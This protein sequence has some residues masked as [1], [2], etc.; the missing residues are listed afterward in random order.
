LKSMQKNCL[1][2]VFTACERAWIS[3]DNELFMWSYE[4]GEDLAYYDGINDTIIA[5]ELA[6][7]RPGLFTNFISH[8]DNRRSAKWNILS[9]V[10]CH[11]FGSY[12]FGCYIC[13]TCPGILQRC[14]RSYSGFTGAPLLSSD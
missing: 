2:G 3:I 10:Y 12:H 9:V 14:T 11:S 13:A 7:P 5:V 4:D 6:V 8:C 1:M